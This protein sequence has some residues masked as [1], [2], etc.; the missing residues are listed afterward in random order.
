MKWPTKVMRKSMRRMLRDLAQSPTKSMFLDIRGRKARWRWRMAQH[1]AARGLAY[2]AGSRPS[3]RDSG[4]LYR[5]LEAF[6]HASDRDAR[7]KVARL[8]TTRIKRPI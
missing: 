1:L 4:P 7:Y 5:E 6:L 2:F 8:P 3:W